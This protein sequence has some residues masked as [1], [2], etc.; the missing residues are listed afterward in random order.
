MWAKMQVTPSAPVRLSGGEIRR[1]FWQLVL[2]VERSA[3]AML[4]MADGKQV[5]SLCSLL[6]TQR[7][8]S[9]WCTFHLVR[10]VCLQILHWHVCRSGGCCESRRRPPPTRPRCQRAGSEPMR[11][12]TG[13]CCIGFPLLQDTH[14]SRGSEQPIHQ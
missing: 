7:V 12:G 6:G 5:V 2:A 4:R 9:D 11:T 3:A 1:L 8:D 10:L 13:A 14:L